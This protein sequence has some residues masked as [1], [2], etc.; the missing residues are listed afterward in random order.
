MRR[1]AAR[2]WLDMMRFRFGLALL[3]GARGAWLGRCRRSRRIST[4][5]RKFAVLMD[6][7]TGSILFDKNADERL[8]PAS[9]AKLMTLAVVFTYLQQNKLSLDDEFFISEHAWRD[10]GAPSGGS[11]MFAMLN[12]KIRVEDLIKWRHRAV[13]QRRGDRAGRRHRRHRAAPSP[14]SRTSWPSRSA[15]PARTSPTPPACRTPTMYSTRARPRDAQPLHHQE[16]PR[17]L[18]DLLDAGVHLEQDPAAEPQFAARDRHR[19]RW[20]Q[21][22]PHRR[23]PAT[24]RWSRRPMTAAG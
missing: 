17:V 19:R 3:A 11:T 16:L 21:D 6:Y 18:S 13:G 23:S 10:G 12:S 15:S 1:A 7:E 14:R 4:P 20:P 22:R 5:R 9:M 8:E 2:N 24:A